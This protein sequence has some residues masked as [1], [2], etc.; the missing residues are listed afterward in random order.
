[1][2]LLR[3][4]LERVTR[5]Q[6]FSYWRQLPDPFSKVRIYVTPDASLK[7]LRREETAFTS[8]LLQ[9]A[10]EYVKPDYCVW[11]IGAN[12]GLF[13][14]SAAMMAGRNGHVIAFEPDP[15]LVGFIQKSMSQQSPN[16]APVTIVEA[17]V[18]KNSGEE[19]F[20][21]ASRGRA[22]NKLESATGSTQMGGIRKVIQVKCVT[23]DA[24]L[25]LYET[26]HLVKMDIEGGEFDALQNA[27]ELL[28]KVRPIIYCEL[29]PGGQSVLQLLNNAKYQIFDPSCS[30]ESLLIS[31]AEKLQNVLALPE[32]ISAKVT[33]QRPTP[34]T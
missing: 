21:I 7:Y 34:Q 9:F 25:G 28:S 13:T 16:S 10:H 4:I 23:I 11:D 29:G 18:S 6:V 1:M 12:L 14:F 26:P 24:M 30:E 19:N 27:T 17:A 33:A 5:F 22:T 2:G 8:D 32:E 31:D 20:Q 3:F 15:K